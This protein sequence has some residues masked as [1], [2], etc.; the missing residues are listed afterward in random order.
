MQKVTPESGKALGEEFGL[1]CFE[2]SAKMNLNVDKAFTSIASDIV[3][4]LKVNPDHYG[5]EGGMNL[6]KD[7]NKA[8]SVAGAKAGCC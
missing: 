5:S 2:T 7:K 6:S 1:Q 8:G 3:E 4:R